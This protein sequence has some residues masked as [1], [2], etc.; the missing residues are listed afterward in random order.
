MQLGAGFD[1]A[2]VEEMHTV[3]SLGTHPSSINFANPCKAPES[4]AFAYK[5]GIRKTTFDNLDELDNI[6]KY[7]PNA[8]LL[9]RIYANDSSAVVSLGDKYGAPLESCHALLVRAR[10]LGM[11][12]DPVLQTLTQFEKQLLIQL[13]WNIAQS[14][15]FSL[16]IVDIGGGFQSTE[17]AFCPMAIAASSAISEASFPEQTEFIG[18]PGRFY[19]CGAFIL[20]CRVISRRISTGPTASKVLEMLYQNDGVFK[21]FMNGLTEKEVFA[22]TLIMS[23]IDGNVARKTGEHAYIIWGPTC[24]STDC[25]TRRATFPCEVRVGDFLVYRNMGAYTSATA[26]RFNGFSSQAGTIYICRRSKNYAQAEECS[27]GEE[28]CSKMA[29]AFKT[30][31]VEL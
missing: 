20:V 2:S 24:S 29:N 9:L 31:T 23:K 5:V 17:T 25:V 12:V 3:L 30:P 4:L 26:T 7:M 13:V 1:C 14:L 21:S 15:G 10:E 16:K 28:D 19:A 11:D 27:S 22:P 18:E 6:K 8:Q